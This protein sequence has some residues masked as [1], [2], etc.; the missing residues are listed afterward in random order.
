M[1][2]NQ[3]NSIPLSHEDARTGTKRAKK[4]GLNLGNSK[5]P[6]GPG[7]RGFAY[8]TRNMGQTGTD[9]CSNLWL[10]CALSRGQYRTKCFTVFSA[11]PRQRPVNYER[12]R[13]KE[14]LCWLRPDPGWVKMDK[15]FLLGG[16]SIQK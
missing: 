10:A 9:E 13:F 11:P 7:N 16:V 14:A 12:D 8:K 4:R 15:N 1:A 6:K 3:A 5:Y 2:G